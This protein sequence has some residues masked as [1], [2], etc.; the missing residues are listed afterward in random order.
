M[1]LAF[2]LAAAFDASS[3]SASE[4]ELQRVLTP[5]AKYWL[6]KR[7]TPVAL[8]AMEC[9]GGNGYVEE[10]PLARL[11]PRGAAERHLGG[12]RQ[13]DLPRCPEALGR[14]P[15]A[16][17]IAVRGNRILGR[18]A[19]RRAPGRDREDARR[20]RPCP[21]AKRG[22]IVGA[23]AV[24]VQASLMKR[25]SDAEAAEAFCMS[26][27]PATA[28]RRSGRWS[29]RGFRGDPAARFAG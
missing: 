28:G 8:E 12:K 1:L 24:C 16:W 29:E 21:S 20:R 9:L 27:L 4:R 18:P 13:R 5:I 23:L 10:A 15:E 3:A 14:S 19:H 17:R 6:C 2:R 25:Q 11:Y 26:R 22:A 7:I